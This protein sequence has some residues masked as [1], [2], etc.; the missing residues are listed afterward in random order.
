MLTLAPDVAARLG[1][2][3][4]GGTTIVIGALLILTAVAV[5]AWVIWLSRR[6][7]R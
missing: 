7:W 6:P 4:Y 5:V 2:F 1:P 3:R